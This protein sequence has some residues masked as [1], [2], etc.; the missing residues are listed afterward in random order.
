MRERILSTVL[1]LALS[2]PAQ[3]PSPTARL[4]GIVRDPQQRPVA[5]AVVTVEIDGEVRGRTQTDGS[6]TFVFGKVPPQVAIV[7]AQTKTPDVGGTWVDLLG[8]QRGFIQVVLM[9]ARP[10]TGTVRDDAGQPVAGAWVTAA[11][12]DAI[13][14]AFASCCAQSDA[15]GHYELPGV[16]FGPVMVRAWAEGHDA[17]EGSIDGSEA[18][19]LDCRIE[20]DAGQEHTFHLAEATPAQLTA[21][22]LVVQALHNGLPVP[23]PPPLRRLRA[24]PDGTWKVRGWPYADDLLVQLQLPGTAITPCLHTAYAGRGSTRGTFAV[25][26]PATCLRGRL[27]GPEGLPLA[28]RTL[29]V[30]AMNGATADSRRRAVGRADQD[31]TFTI[32]S[33]VE[34]DETFALRIVD[35]EATVA[36][37]VPA[38]SWFIAKHTS[39]RHVVPIQ[40]THNIRLQVLDADRVPVPGAGITLHAASKLRSLPGGLVSLAADGP[41]LGSGTSHLDG[42]VEITG[43]QLHPGESL[44]CLT[45]AGAGMHEVVFQVGAA[46]TIDLGAVKLI[47]AAT[48]Q[49]QA[50]TDLGKP[51]PGARVKL[52]TYTPM[53]MPIRVAITDRAGQLTFTGL[54]PTLN[55]AWLPTPNPNGHQQILSP[56]ANAAELR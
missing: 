31:G 38:R 10:L 29:L 5:G 19:V 13:E 53:G 36:A 46:T 22:I 23:L 49:V 40:P 8:L 15:N 50:Q 12:N 56:G 6:G 42:K 41:A 37:E 51:W 16:P 44:A 52:Q 14:F 9:P 18:A 32:T 11:P 1:L 27:V 4:E 28:N 35:D 55:V 30:L 20:A 21:A 47:E 48:L 43:L 26:D 45:L 39:T 7:R 3:V 24:G 54:L 33:P 2:A 25:A 34:R 17:F